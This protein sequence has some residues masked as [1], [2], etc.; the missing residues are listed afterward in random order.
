MPNYI[1]V[2]VMCP[3]YKKTG[4]RRIHCESLIAR[5]ATWHYFISCQAMEKHM[6]TYCRDIKKWEKCP[7]GAAV[8]RKYRD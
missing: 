3:F 1:D 5:A 8:G 6:E 4:E 7:Y 2:E